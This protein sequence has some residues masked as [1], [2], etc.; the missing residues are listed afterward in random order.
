MMGHAAGSFKQHNRTKFLINQCP[1][2]LHMLEFGGAAPITIH[3]AAAISMEMLLMVVRVWSPEVC[4]RDLLLFCVL[5]GVGCPPL[6]NGALGLAEALLLVAASGVGH[7]HCEL[8]LHSDVV[9][10]GDISDLHLIEA[11]QGGIRSSG[12]A[13]G[14]KLGKSGQ[15]TPVLAE[16]LNL[17]GRH[18]GNADPRCDPQLGKRADNCAGKDYVLYCAAL[19]GTSDPIMNQR[20]ARGQ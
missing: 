20:H 15:N 3:I 14:L 18:F 9:L 17:G 10:Q 13:Q 12:C 16:Q 5:A 2:P 7:I 1:R 8:R 4:G 19:G 11:A 6:H